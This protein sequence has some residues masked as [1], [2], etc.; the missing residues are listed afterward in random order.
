MMHSKRQPFT[1][2][3]FPYDGTNIPIKKINYIKMR[4]LFLIMKRVLLIKSIT[5]RLVRS[6]DNQQFLESRPQKRLYKKELIIV[7]F[8]VSREVILLAVDIGDSEIINLL[9]TYISRKKNKKKTYQEEKTNENRSLQELSKSINTIDV[10]HITSEEENYT[11]SDEINND[12]CY[13]NN[14]IPDKEV[15][16]SKVLQDI[17]NPAHIIER[18]RPSKRRYMSSTEKER[19]R[20]EPSS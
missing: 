14:A 1:F 10:N 13:T 11:N 9:Q 3:W 8:G 15:T 16:G 7:K 2:Q 6:K 19:S 17:Q 4:P 12:D 5:E 18:E 20:E